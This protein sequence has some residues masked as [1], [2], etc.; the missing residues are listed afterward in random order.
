MRWPN[1]TDA[2]KPNT[3]LKTGKAMR[4]L[5]PEAQKAVEDVVKLWDFCQPLCSALKQRAY[6]IGPA[7]RGDLGCGARIT[8]NG[9]DRRWEQWGEVR[10]TAPEPEFPT[11]ARVDGHPFSLVSRTNR[12]LTALATR[13][14]DPR[15][16]QD[17]L[18]SRVLTDERG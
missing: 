5:D 12:P 8:G 6:S 2:G 11:V 16:R 10:S 13:L 17:W 14:A 9:R 3:L 18:L 15:G 4:R 7:V 1:W